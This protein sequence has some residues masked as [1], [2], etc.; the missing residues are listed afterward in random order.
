MVK[1]N[2]PTSISSHLVSCCIQLNFIT[3]IKACW[4]YRFTWFPLAID[5]NQPLFL[6]SSQDGTQHLHRVDESK[7]CW[8]ADTGMSRCGSQHENVFHEFV[9]TSLVMASMCCLSNK[10]GWGE[11][12][13]VAIELLFC[14]M[15]LSR[16]IQN[17]MQVTSIS[18]VVFFGVY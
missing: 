13:K 18:Y 12:R 17:S 2:L 16:L 11:R 14:R 1:H 15:L 7:F 8:L 10:D 4:Q 5:P 9:L 3:I 6:V